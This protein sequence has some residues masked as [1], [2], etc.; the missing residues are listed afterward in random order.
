MCTKNAKCNTLKNREMQL[1][2]NVAF[3]KTDLLIQASLGILVSSISHRDCILI[4]NLS[5]TTTMYIHSYGA[6]SFSLLTL[7]LLLDISPSLSFFLFTNMFLSFRSF[8][9]LCFLLGF[10]FSHT[11]AHSLS[12]LSPS[13]S[14]VGRRKGSFTNKNNAKTRW[15]D[16]SAR[17]LIMTARDFILRLAPIFLRVYNVRESMMHE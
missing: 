6:D 2:N 7:P 16:R 4:M 8:L 3:W 12:V 13:L 10:S 1:N 11:L 5:S 17:I 14:S 9:F 15:R